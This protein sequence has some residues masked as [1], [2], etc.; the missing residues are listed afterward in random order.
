M[1]GDKAR[2]PAHLLTYFDKLCPR[3]VQFILNFFPSLLQ[4]PHG[5]YQLSRGARVVGSGLL[6]RRKRAKRD[7]E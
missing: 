7:G 2:L 1:L 3:L 6:V 5:V 4:Q